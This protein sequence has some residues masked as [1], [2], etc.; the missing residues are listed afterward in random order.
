MTDLPCN[1]PPDLARSLG[2]RRVP[3]ASNSAPITPATREALAEF[4]RTKGASH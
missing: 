4:L 2:I 1:F 3:A